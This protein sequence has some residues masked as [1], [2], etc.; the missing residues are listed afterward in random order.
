MENTR[1]LIASKIN[2]ESFV[3]WLCQREGD[4]KF[5]VY[6]GLDAMNSGIENLELT[7][8][9]YNCLK[10]A[11]YSTINSVVDDVECR[12]DFAKVRNMGRKSTNEF[13]LKLFLYTYENLKPEKRKAYL[14]KVKGL[15]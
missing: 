13:M 9:P 10:R 15:N 5:I 2:D 1:E 12:Q 8:R 6:Q 3:D 11:G 4:F 7:P 14:D